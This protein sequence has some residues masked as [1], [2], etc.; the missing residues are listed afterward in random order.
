MT[1]K[2]DNAAIDVKDLSLVFVANS[3]S[4][5]AIR[6]LSFTATPGEFL[7]LVGTSG[8]GKTS[9]LNVIAGFISPS[10][11]QVLMDGRPIAG[12]SADRVMVF[13]QHALFPWKTVWKN[14]EFGLRMKAMPR[15]ERRRSVAEHLDLV[16]LRGF[17]DQYPAYLSSGMQQ[18]VGLARA[19]A[20]KPK[21]LLMDEPFG[22]LDAQTRLMMQELLLSIWERSK[23]T[24]LFVTHDVDEAVL[25][26]DR[27]IVLTAR[28]ARTR[29]SMVVPLQRP[30]K[31]QMTAAKEYR[32]VRHK[33]FWL[34]REESLVD[35][36]VGTS[37]GPRE[38]S[39]IRV[40][41]YPGVGEAVP[42]LLAQD[43]GLFRD[44]GLHVD[45]VSFDSGS[46][47][48]SVVARGGLQAGATGAAAFLCAVQEG[49]PLT[50]TR[51]HA[52]VVSGSG[53]P[54]MA[55]CVRKGQN[56][57]SLG[58]LTGRTVAVNGFGT[59]NSTLLRIASEPYENF[60]SFILLPVP[61]GG[62]LEA[63]QGGLADAAVLCEPYL[64]QSLQAG[65]VDIIE[66]LDQLAVGLPAWVLS[67]NSDW[68]EKRRDVA[69]RFCRAYDRAIEVL[70]R[71]P[72]AGR[73][74]T[75][76]HLIPS[77]TAA[78]SAVLPS[79]TGCLD[80]DGLVGFQ[81]VLVR[82]RVL[83]GPTDLTDYLDDLVPPQDEQ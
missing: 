27:V 8:C 52:H 58:D 64:G 38:R 71:C 41:Y 83:R 54:S 25:L 70:G 47:V 66:C 17:E 21:V 3:G 45:S 67:F 48:T 31:P 10:S 7:C 57:R 20:V 9:L 36:F 40:G 82:S 4:T 32:Q 15:R 39:H 46:I 37:T 62:A 19:L 72:Q 13:Q 81:E 50:A 77:G 26:G 24:V 80:R 42:L 76:D 49:Q 61:A 43:N 11:G 59:L 79:W 35:H 33:V 16:G 6:A 22:S 23:T 78:A 56:I 69:I 30:R 12:P 29:E 2:P 51:T 74:V 1:M 5:E 63:M 53:Q 73:T 14:V 75:Q 28:P 68:L 34:I 60:G 55:V 44:E 18:R 65:L